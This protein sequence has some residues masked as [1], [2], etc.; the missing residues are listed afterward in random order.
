MIRSLR[1]KLLIFILPL[2]LIP[3]IGISFTITRSVQGGEVVPTT[4]DLARSERMIVTE[5]PSHIQKLK[6]KN[7]DLAMAWRRK[8]RAVFAHYLA[9]GYRVVGLMLAFDEAGPLTR[10]FYCLEKLEA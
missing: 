8:T 9:S 7:P 10:S 5:I 3:L 6:A 4:V 2:C 1:Q